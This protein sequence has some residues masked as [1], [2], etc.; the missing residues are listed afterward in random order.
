M[1]QEALWLWR[2]EVINSVFLFPCGEWIGFFFRIFFVNFQV[3]SGKVAKSNPPPRS[4]PLS[5]CCCDCCCVEKAWPK[6]RFY[7][8]GLGRLGDSTPTCVNTKQHSAA[9]LLDNI[10]T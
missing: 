5:L 9:K 2:F 6:N 1:L 4:P 7:E 3:C 10:S 8:N